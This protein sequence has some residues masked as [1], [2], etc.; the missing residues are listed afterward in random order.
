MAILL[1]STTPISLQYGSPVKIMP[2]F[3]FSSLSPLMQIRH[4]LTGKKG[5]SCRR[6]NEEI[7][8]YILCA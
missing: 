7:L 1:L 8:R 2:G 5:T 4:S 3:H 6:E